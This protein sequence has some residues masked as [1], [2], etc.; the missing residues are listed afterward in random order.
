ME[1]TKC[2][3]WTIA[4]VVSFGSLAGGIPPGPPRNSAEG[5]DFQIL[6][7]KLVYDLGTTMRIRFVVLNTG[8]SPLYLYRGLNECSSQM[9]S[10][11]FLILDPNEKDARSEGC[12]AEFTMQDMNVLT[13]LSDSSSWIVLGPEEM[14]GKQIG[15]PVPTK[16]GIYHLKAEL[17]PPGFTDKQRETLLKKHIR[18]LDTPCMAPEVVITV[19]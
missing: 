6:P 3:G 8:D 17:K 1:K 12:S 5:V 2:L 4:A 11:F 18:I 15:F 16:K 14:F 19:K 7:D 10:F 13:S 9:G